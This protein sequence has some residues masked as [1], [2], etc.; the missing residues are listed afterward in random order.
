MKT[1][2]WS[3]AKEGSDF[4]RVLLLTGRGQTPGMDLQDGRVFACP[5]KLTTP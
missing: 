2:K 1:T 5:A 3:K 4:A